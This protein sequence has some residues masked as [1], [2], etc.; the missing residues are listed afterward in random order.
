MSIP[1][2]LIF[3]WSGTN[4]TIPTNW[5]RETTL[6]GRFPKGAPAA[7]AG[8]TN[9]GNATHTHTSPGHTHTMSAH[10]HAIVTSSNSHEGAAQ[11]GSGSGNM[12]NQTHTHSGSIP[13][14]SYTIDTVAVTYA[15]VSNNPPYHEVIFIK[16]SA[17][18]TLQ[19]NV[20]ALWAGW[21]GDTDTPDNWQYCDGTNSSPDLRNKYLRGAATAG[22]AGG[23]G[24][25]TA[26]TH[27][28]DHGHT[29]SH[30][31]SGASGGPSASS[32]ELQSSGGGS[33]NTAAHTHTINLASAAGS[34]TSTINLVTVETVEPLYKKLGA[35]QRRAGGLKVRGLIG[36]WLGALADI[37]RG[38]VLCNGSNG[39]PDLRDYHLK[40]ANTA[41]EFEDTGGSN[42]HTHAAQGHT[43]TAGSTHT[44]TGSVLAAAAVNGATGS[45]HT[46]WHNDFTHSS[47]TSVDSQTVA[48]AT[49][50]TTANSSNNEPLYRTISFVQF[51]TP[52]DGGAFLLN[53]L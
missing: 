23:T 8:G 5:T 28:I 30:T 25:S 35:I 53:M 12:R 39:T 34:V 1:V 19:D 51:Q 9:G 29:D 36:M 24:G 52:T 26:N 33:G 38:F 14:N 48:Y 20:I 3:I 45:G 46:Y 18:A 37:P 22:N 21:D 41:G 27:A 43:H 4:G 10:S 16:A 7:T 44:H 31:H 42:T 15:S 2:D 13:I 6:D 32:G 49:S 47:L 50:D 40:I 17:G 11:T